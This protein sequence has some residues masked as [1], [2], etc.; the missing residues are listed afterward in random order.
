MACFPT[1]EIVAYTAKPASAHL[2]KSTDA[3]MIIGGTD[4]REGGASNLPR[5]ELI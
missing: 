3:K 4:L 5:T 1:N 2:S